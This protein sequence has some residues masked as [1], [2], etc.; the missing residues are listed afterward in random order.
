MRNLLLS[1]ILIAVPVAGFVG[2]EMFL[3]AASSASPAG[4]G[5]LSAFTQIITDTKVIADAGD[6]AAAEKRITDF[7]TLWDDQEAGLRPADPT[8]WG[9]ID[10]AAD[11]SFKALRTAKPDQAA[12]DAALSALLGS[13]Q[14]PAATKG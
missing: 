13:L 5:D 12:V 8:A 9:A 2:V 6:M 14:K 3:P 4:L 1:A 11:T 10:A 7:E